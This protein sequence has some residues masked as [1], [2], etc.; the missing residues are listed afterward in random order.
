MFYPEV[1]AGCRDHIMVQGSVEPQ[2]VVCPV[3]CA[4]LTAQKARLHCPQCCLRH[5]LCYA[6][7]EDVLIGLAGIQE[8][9]FVTISTYQCCGPS[10]FSVVSI[11]TILFIP[12][13]F[14]DSSTC[15]CCM[16][17]P[18][19]LQAVFRPWIWLAMVRHVRHSTQSQS[20]QNFLVVVK[21]VLPH[22]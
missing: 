7:P 3:Q 17:T 1:I 22:Y 19:M 13:M 16:P 6:A 11:S 21:G 15:L 20:A 8:D 10:L 12:G 14:F 2:T 4:H 9:G 5:G 18:S